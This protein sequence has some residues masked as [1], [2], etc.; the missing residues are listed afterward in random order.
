MWNKAEIK[1]KGKQLEGAIKDKAGKL[2]GN[3][4]LEARG[5]AELV[6]GK[7]EEKVGKA[8]RETGAAVVKAA[9]AIAGKL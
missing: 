1:G 5:K 6:T 7:V 2:I 8:R 9:K 4:K 3:P